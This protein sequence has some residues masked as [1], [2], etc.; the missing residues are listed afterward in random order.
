M[1]WGSQPLSLHCVHSEPLSRLIYSRCSWGRGKAGVATLKTRFSS[2]ALPLRR[3][4]G[5]FSGG[6]R[7]RFLNCKQAAATASG[8]PALDFTA[9]QPRLACCDWG[10][11][12]D[13]RVGRL[14]AFRE[15][16][17][18]G[19]RTA[20]FRELPNRARCRVRPTRQVNPIRL[21][22]VRKY[23]IQQYDR[24]LPRCD[25][26]PHNHSFGKATL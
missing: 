10:A 24:R 8:F 7:A 5:D 15:H 19:E 26:D 9:G 16:P 14:S 6:P 3:A 20:I 4:L 1:A 21:Q 18:S 23:D 12:T 17:T 25:G 13:Y 22:L 2:R 11:C